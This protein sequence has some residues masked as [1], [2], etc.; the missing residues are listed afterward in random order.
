MIRR[1]RL[2]YGGH[3]IPV[4]AL[5]NSWM[6]ARVRVGDNLSPIPPRI[7]QRNGAPIKH[8]F[9]SRPFLFL[10]VFRL[11]PRRRRRLSLL[12]AVRFRRPP[13][14]TPS[15]QLHPFLLAPR[16]LL[17]T[18]PSSQLNP[19]LSAPPLPLSTTPS[20][21]LHPLLSSTHYSQLHPFLSAPPLPLS[22]TPSSQRGGAERQRRFTPLE[23][24]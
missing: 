22:T 21:Q 5:T 18:T 1:S 14:Y 20:S 23:R 24:R 6:H 17:N 4:A 16:L 10:F 8:H 19:F 12:G 13:S 3:N 9:P 2:Q 15:S 11:S 7:P